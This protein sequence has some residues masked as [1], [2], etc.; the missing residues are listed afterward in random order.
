MVL[1]SEYLHFSVSASAISL[2]I[3]A[4]LAPVKSDFRSSFFIQGTGIYCVNN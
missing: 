4:E 2:V 1:H 3:I